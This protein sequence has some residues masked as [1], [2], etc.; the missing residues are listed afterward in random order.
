MRVL[1]GKRHAEEKRDFRPRLNEG[2]ACTSRPIRMTVVFL[3][4]YCSWQ[5]RSCRFFRIRLSCPSC[6]TSVSLSTPVLLSL[7]P[8]LCVAF[9]PWCAFSHLNPLGPISLVFFFSLDRS[10][11]G[12]PERLRARGGSVGV[13]H[14][15]SNRPDHA[16]AGQGGREAGSGGR[17]RRG[18]QR[19]GERGLERWGVAAVAAGG[20][21]VSV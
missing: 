9:N 5:P 10:F 18:R 15:G 16:D 21:C 14:H 11:V 8:P 17:G 7:P 4:Y 1:P 19:R 3:L 12:K 13:V 6:L 20:G 2:E